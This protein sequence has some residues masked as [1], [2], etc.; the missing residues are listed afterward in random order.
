MSRILHRIVT[1]CVAFVFAGGGPGPAPDPDVCGDGI[2]GATE[3]CDD[4]NAWLGDGCTDRCTIEEGPLEEE[5]NDAWSAAMAWPGAPFVGS[6]PEGDVDCVRFDVEPCSAVRASLV[7]ACPPGVVLALHDASGALVASG[8][9]GADGCARVDP[10][11]AP[12]ARWLA[13]PTAAVCARSLQGNPIP[14]YT[15]EVERL[16]SEGLGEGDDDAD[17]DG[18]ADR[19]D[20]DVDGDGVDDEWDNCPSVPNGPSANARATG[21]AGF[22]TDWLA[23]GPIVDPVSPDRCLPSVQEL[24]PGDPTLAPQSGDEA[25]GLVWFPLLDDARVDLLETLGSVPAPREAYVH[26]Y[27]IVDVPVDLTLAVG[28]DDGVRAWIDGEPVLEVASCQGVEPDQFQ[29]PVTLAAGVHRLTLKVRDNGGGWGLSVRFLD[30]SGE[31]FGDLAVSLAPDAP[32][33]ADLDGDG[34]GDA[35]DPTPGG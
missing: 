6:L 7:G 22:V 12:G 10:E 34:I 1:H 26:T 5:P 13:G 2:T 29:A 35:C 8:P 17:R 27:V 25:L 3:A 20:D 18:V 15:L 23:L 19:C 21:A 28:V 16:S 11:I 30:P 24:P 4:G 33:Q 14:G 9:P 31:P 32:P